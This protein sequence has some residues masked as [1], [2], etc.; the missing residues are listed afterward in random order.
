MIMPKSQYFKLSKKTLV[1][2]IDYRDAQIEH[3]RESLAENNKLTTMY[4]A[5]LY[6]AMEFFGVDIPEGVNPKD[7]A[8]ALNTVAGPKSEIV[9]ALRRAKK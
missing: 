3:L 6:N 1:A 9:K 5:A 2:R 4:A 7:L 8:E